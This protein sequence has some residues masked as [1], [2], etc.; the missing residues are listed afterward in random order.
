[1]GDTSRGWFARALDAP[2]ALRWIALLA[3]ALVLPTLG[4]G[5]ILDDWSHRLM[6]NPAWHHPGAVRGPW[7]LYRFFTNDL[8]LRRLDLDRGILPWWTAPGFRLAFMRPLGSLSLALD[9]TVFAGLPW[10]WHLENALWFGA[11]TLSA[12]AVFKVTL[13]SSRVVALATLLV[14]VDHTHA[15][16]AVL[17]SNRHA[18]LAA[19]FA[20]AS[21]AAH[22]RWRNGDARARTVALGLF[23]AALLCGESTFAL[24][25]YLFAYTLWNDPD[26]SPA[27]WRALAPYALLVAVWAVVYRA[28]GCG[29]FGGDFYIDPVRQPLTF[30]RAAASRMPILALGQVALPPSEFVGPR[31]LYVSAI[32][33]AVL[34]AASVP[35]WRLVRHDAMAKTW[36]F[37]A[38]L[39]LVP[40]CATF[41]GDRLLLF[42]GL[43]V[44]ALFAIAFERVW[45]SG[46]TSSRGARVFVGA[47][48]VLHLGLS[49]LLLPAR[50]VNI[51]QTA[52]G[53]V[54]RADR[55]LPHDDAVR[56]QMLMI[57]TSPDTLAPVYVMARREPEGRPTPTR[58]FRL[59]AMA[60]R[61]TTTLRRDTAQS[62][63]ITSS[64]GIPHDMFGALYR[65]AAM[66]FHL[67]DT[68]VTAG[69][70]AT[71]TALTPDGLARE[72]RFTWDRDLDDARYRWVWWT[73][74]HY[75]PFPLPA[76]GGSVTLEPI[77]WIRAMMG[78]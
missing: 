69:M 76:V 47:L 66:P 48:A 75:E 63:V 3:V 74:F 56:G 72:T 34:T 23:V 33:A 55:S 44:M 43:G 5:M 19:V 24:G 36:V 68:V 2:H 27:R 60:T 9:H 13:K 52:G 25:G 21:F 38:L 62:V 8:D 16:L 15:M 39:A 18:V 57:V 1:M 40:G 14:A 61:G 29:A 64:E 4:T 28:Q 59:M 17:I 41:P 54:E 42:S 20:F 50:A 71:V 30:L 11:L 58:G 10:V 49:P 31:P 26:R 7:E 46:E 35:A 32:I 70:T 78:R 12:A 51:A 37:G 65:G 6:M 45:W 53:F 67:G 22:L 77:D 73:H